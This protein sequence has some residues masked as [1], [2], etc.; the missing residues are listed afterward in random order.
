MDENDSHD[1]ALSM[2]SCGQAVISSRSVLD[3]RRLKWLL[4]CRGDRPRVPR[5]CVRPTRKLLLLLL[6][7]VDGTLTAR[8]TPPGLRG[9]HRGGSDPSTRAPGK[10]LGSSVFF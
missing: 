10:S 5:S 6:P 9:A 7:V 4:R 3:F 2:H 8:W 1:M